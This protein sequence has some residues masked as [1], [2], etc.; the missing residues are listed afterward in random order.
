MTKSVTL[1]TILG[2]LHLCAGETH[3]VITKEIGSI[4]FYERDWK[5][6]FGLNLKAYIE[7]GLVLQNTTSKLTEMCNQTPVVLNCKYFEQN[8][9]INTEMV[10]NDINQLTKYKRSKRSFWGVLFKGIL[11]D[12]LMFAG[13]VTITELMSA[14]KIEKLEDSLQQTNEQLMKQFNITVLQNGLILTTANA[15]MVLQEEVANLNQTLHN[16]EKFNELLMIATQAIANHNRDTAKYINIVRGDFRAN[17][18]SIIDLNLFLEKMEAA[19]NSLGENGHFPTTNP[20]DLLDLSPITHSENET[21]I[22]IIVSAPIIARKPYKLYEFVPLP[23]KVDKTLHVLQT[24]PQ[25]YFYDKNNNTK[26][27]L[28]T[29]FDER[30]KTLNKHII[31][32]SMV[33]N[34]FHDPEECMHEILF[35]T[36]R[37]H[38]KHFRLHYQNYLIPL[39]PELIYAFIVH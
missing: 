18:F 2:I 3:D 16:Q 7:N 37:N 22:T 28:T 24:P 27:A 14:S 17:F 13:A 19:Q 38:C 31:C 1:A 4:S 10:Q 11:K 15:S 39:E 32:N 25:F 33:L 20:F 34:D 5:L 23:I 12:I 9:K 36:G 35:R 8:I 6:V 29:S 26:A 30:C 21:H